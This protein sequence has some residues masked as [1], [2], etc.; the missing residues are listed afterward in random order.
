[1]K[2]QRRE[3]V[4]RIILTPRAPFPRPGPFRN[5]HVTRAAPWT[6]PLEHGG[7][8]HHR[9]STLMNKGLEA[10]GRAGCSTGLDRI[11]HPGPPQSHRHSMIEMVDGSVLDSWAFQ[12]GIPIAVALAY[13]GRLPLFDLPPLGLPASRVSFWETDFEKF[14]ACLCPGSGTPGGCVQPFS[15]PPTSWPVKAFLDESIGYRYRRA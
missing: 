12:H 2:G 6:I 8:D 14:R 7:Q 13:P 10:I 11:F 1:M 4:K 5:A 9:F 15:T 3:D